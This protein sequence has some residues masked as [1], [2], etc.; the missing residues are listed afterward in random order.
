MGNIGENKIIV[1]I[2]ELLV[3]VAIKVF[4]LGN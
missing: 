3:C 4:I 2:D 1:N